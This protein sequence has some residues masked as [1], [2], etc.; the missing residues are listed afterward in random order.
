M[1]ILI[2][3]QFWLNK[4]DTVNMD[5]TALDRRQLPVGLPFSYYGQFQ[6]Y[7]GPSLINNPYRPWSERFI[8]HSCFLAAH[9]H[10]R[11]FR[12]TRKWIRSTRAFLLLCCKNRLCN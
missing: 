1:M 2:K 11:L 5:D 9:Y 7:E 4:A 12:L 8:S 10:Q 3:I 6:N